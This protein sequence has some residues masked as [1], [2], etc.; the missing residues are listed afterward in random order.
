MQAAVIK[1]KNLLKIEEVSIPVIGKNDVL[2]KVRAVGLCKTDIEVFAGEHPFTQKKFKENSK[3]FNLIP[4]HEWSGIIDKMGNLCCGLSVGDHV[5]GETT[6]SCGKC[7]NCSSGLPDLCED[8]IEIGIT[9]DGAMAEY[10]S[11]PC[12]ILHKIPDEISFIDAAMIEP[13]AV[14]IHA[15]KRLSLEI[16]QDNLK[17]KIVVIFGDGPIALLLFQVLQLKKPKEIIIIGKSSKKLAVAR[18]LGCRTIIDTSGLSEHDSIANIRKELVSF[19]IDVI[20]DATSNFA[21]KDSA[22]VEGLN[23]VR[24]QGIV[25]LVGMH[26][27][28][29]IGIN[30]IVLNELKV[31]GAVSSHGA[32]PEAIR[33]LSLKKIQTQPLISDI[34]LADLPG[35]FDKSTKEPVDIIKGI[36]HFQ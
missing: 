15:V 5:I 2:I 18:K 33:L 6:M 32:W 7:A 19:R 24:K 11:V 3:E 17:E 34:S 8:P 16:P 12:K 25:L 36:I 9:R 29:E 4:G 23:I 30:T 22:I 31:I 10:L 26:H 13:L 28:T 35:L 14:A 27:P 21:Y 1:G 20:I